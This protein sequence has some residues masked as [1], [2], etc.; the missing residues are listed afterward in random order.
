MAQDI[1]ADIAERTGGD[2]YI[3]VV[4][5][6]RTGKSTFINRFMEQFV[7]PNIESDFRKE[8]AIDELP[9]SSAGK[10]IM[11]TE[12][13]FIPEEAVR[14]TIDGGTSFNVR[15]IDCVGYIIP[16]AIG[17]IE[18]DSPR[19]VDTPWFDEPVPFNMAAEVGTE[20]VITQ[21]STI[22]LVVTTDGSITDLPR[23]EYEE[24]EQRVIKELQSTT[25]G[26]LLLC[27]SFMTRCSH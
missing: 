3:G 18:N 4:G 12:P 22:G 19:M 13:K 27:S 21:H 17:Y 14:V 16:S 25:N 8:R 9:Q 5:P 20:K 26:L 11:T 10:T 15:M 24:C 1:Y 2:I 7:I 6:V 23:E